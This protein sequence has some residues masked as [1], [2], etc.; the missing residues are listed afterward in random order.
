MERGEV[1]AVLPYEAKKHNELSLKINDHLIIKRKYGD[2][3]GNKNWWAKMKQNTQEGFVPPNVLGVSFLAHKRHFICE[4]E[5]CLTEFVFVL[6]KMKYEKYMFYS[7][8][9]S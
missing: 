2:D 4:I 7:Q 3:S 6:D 8:F 5:R 1:Y 9:Y